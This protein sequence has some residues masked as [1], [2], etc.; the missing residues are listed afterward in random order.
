MILFE[1]ELLDEAF[2][3]IRPKK[4]R[5]AKGFGAGLRTLVWGSFHRFPKPE[6]VHEHGSEL[7]SGKFVTLVSF[8]GTTSDFSC[9]MFGCVPSSPGTDIGFAMH[10]LSLRNGH[11]GSRNKSED[12]TA[13]LSILSPRLGVT[14][15]AFF[16]LQNGHFLH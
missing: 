11:V 12:A 4:A 8:A 13:F 14:L 1:L 3:E 2:L 10:V 6:R 5:F 9:S 16:W 15:P 7:L